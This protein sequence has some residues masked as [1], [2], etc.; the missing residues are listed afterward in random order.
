MVKEFTENLQD[1]RVLASR[2]KPANTSHDSDSET[3]YKSG[4]QEAQCFYS[5]PKMATQF[6]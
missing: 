6:G 5:L 1:E 4:I 3:S 2:D